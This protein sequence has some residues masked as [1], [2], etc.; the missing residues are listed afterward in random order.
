MNSKINIVLIASAALAVLGTASSFAAPKDPPPANV[1]PATMPRVA[2]IDER[3]QS[4]NIEMVEVTGGRFWKP[5]DQPGKA[6]SQ[7]PGKRRPISPPARINPA[8]NT[9]LPST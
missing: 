5:Y 3:F 7:P 6:T 4:Y 9:A 2:T 1:T 8:F